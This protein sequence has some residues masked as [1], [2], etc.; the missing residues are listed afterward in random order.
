MIGDI[1]GD[2]LMFVL[3][4]WLCDILLLLLLF[5]EG[6]LWFGVCVGCVGKF[7]CIGFNYLDYVVEL[8]MEVLKEFVVFGKWMS[9]IFGLNDDVEILCGF[10]KI[11]WE[12]EFGVVIG[13]GGCYI[14]EVDVLLYVVGYCVV[15]DVLECEY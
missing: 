10:E 2:V 5:V 9:V 13:W 8:G 3:F 14:D 6:M 12:V 4:V 15:N 1:V 7:I 11:D